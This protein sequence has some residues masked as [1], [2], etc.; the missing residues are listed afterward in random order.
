M[1]DSI[2]G[3]LTVWYASV[4][5]VVLIAAGMISYAFAR[6][7]IQRSTDSSM[8]ATARQFA[9]S[10]ADEAAESHGTLRV[11]SANELL[12]DYRDNDRGILLLT[13]DGREFAAH[14][15][16]PAKSLDRALLQR[17]AAKRQFGFATLHHG[18]DVRLF[19]LPAR[20]GGDSFVIAIAQSLAAQDDTLAD[21]REAA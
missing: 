1:I 3:R 21:L 13:G 20:I 5:V 17:R 18:P 2:R 19:L 10:L 8:A 11:R 9:A 14:T 7:Q 6:R 16:P 4:L 12:A 15:T